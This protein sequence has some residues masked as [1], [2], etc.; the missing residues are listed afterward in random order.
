MPTTIITKYGT[1]APTTSDVVQGEL[2]VD[3]TNKRLYTQDGSSVIE[4]GTNPAANVTF[5][6]N[7]KAVFGAGSDLQIYHDTNDSYISDQGSGNLKL[8][9][10]EFRLR[11]AADSAHM[12]TGSQGGAI[13]AYHNGSAKLATTA[14]GIDVTGSVVSDGLTV[15]TDTLVVDATNNRVGIGTDSPSQKLHISDSAP[16]ARLESTSTSYN[17]FTTKN[18]SGNFYFGIDDSGGT[19]YGSAYARAIYA[20]GAYPVTFYTNATE[21][22]RIDSSGNLL[23]GK[24]SVGTANEGAEIR[25]QL[26]AFTADDETPLYLRRLSTDGELI[27]FKQGTSFVG[28]IGTIGTDLYIGSGGAGVRFYESDNSIIPCSDAGVA[29]N[30]S[31]DLG[32]GSFRF[33]D[34]YLSGELKLSGSKGTYTD[35]QT[36]LSATAFN[37]GESSY[38]I[39]VAGDALGTLFGSNFTIDGSTYTQGNTARSS[40]YFGISNTTA[41]GDTS[42]LTYSGFTKGTTTPVERF[43]VDGDG[44]LLVG[45]SSLS[46]L[47]TTNEIISLRAD[48]Y[49]QIAQTGTGTNELAYFYNGNGLVGKISTNGSATTYATS[50]DQRLKENIVDAPSASDD[51]D[52]IQVRSFDWKVDGSHQKYGMVAQ[53]LQSVAPE[54]VSQP[55]DPEEMMGVDYSKLVPMMLK[56]IQQLR[57]RVAQ[58]EGA[59]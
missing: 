20:D 7:V 14:T 45:G 8:L 57:A 16:F 34:L 59:N 28:S 4:L 50:S 36:V 22:M 5:G 58:L 47:G 44:N 17:G 3:T 10:D 56:E 19:F 1:T 21:R 33:K 15:D 43:R 11:S 46:S 26:A 13:T 39:G 41:A 30:G 51:I 2:A 6:D 40:G 29:S 25:P 55:E 37:D 42:I 35:Y 32:D 53:E 49:L 9:T 48:H 27:N 18:D 23:V 31:I 12:L 52:A 38:A 24:T 54:A